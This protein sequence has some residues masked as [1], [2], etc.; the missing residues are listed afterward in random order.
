MTI[1]NHLCSIYMSNIYICVC[2]YYQKY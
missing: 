1:G 2:V